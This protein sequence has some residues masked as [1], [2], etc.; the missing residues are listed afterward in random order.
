[1]RELTFDL[2]GLFVL[3]FYLHVPLMG[4]VSCLATEPSGPD[5]CHDNMAGYHV[6]NR[7]RGEKE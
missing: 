2:R 3:T 4:D 1:M 7:E 5:C 6:E